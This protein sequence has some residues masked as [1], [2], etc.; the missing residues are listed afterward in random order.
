MAGENPDEGVTGATDEFMS[1]TV[2]Q[3]AG[4]IFAGPFMNYVLAIVLLS[5]VAYF[6][7][8]PKIDQ[9]QIT[10]GQVTEDGP[11][12]KAGLLPDDVIIAVDGEPISNFDSLRTQINA[13]VLEPIALSWVHASDTITKTIVTEAI[14]AAN[15]E[16]GID[17]VG[18][19]GFNPKIIG[20]DNFGFIESCRRG[21]LSTHMIVYETVRFVKNLITGQVSP[22]M[23]GGPVFIAQ[24]SGKEAQKGPT[25]L[26]FFMAVLSVNLAVLNVLPIPILDGGHLVFLTIELIKGKPL[27]MK[28][29]GIAQQIGLVLLLSLIVFA[30]YND[31]LRVI[32]EL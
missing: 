15:A 10:V 23:M 31:I 19:I 6:G 24:Q 11:A 1:K 21:F 29:R 17:S 2:W 7:G 9:T 13:R 25:S 8:Q 30:T 16:G 22:K 12:D 3:R 20:Y 4:V 14:P 5:G 28:A 27:S 32:K 18:I 26:F